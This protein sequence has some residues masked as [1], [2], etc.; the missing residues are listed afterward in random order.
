MKIYTDNIDSLRKNADLLKSGFV[1]TRPQGLIDSFCL[2]MDFYS[3]I[4]DFGQKPDFETEKILEK[5]TKNC[6]IVYQKLRALSK[7]RLQSFID[8]KE[9]HN[10]IAFKMVKIYDRDFIIRSIKPLY[11][12]EN[13]MSEII[14][15]FLNDEFNQAD[16]FKKMA[17]EGR[18]I[19]SGLGKIEEE[20]NTAGFTLYDYLNN[21][22]FI[23]LSNDPS[24]V[25]IQLMS[26]IIHEFGHVNDNFN[27][28]F[29]SKKENFSYKTLSSYSEVY[30]ILYEKLF[31]DHLIKNRI[32]KSNSHT[33]LAF[34][35]AEIYNNFNKLGYLSTLDDNIL[36]NEKYKKRVEDLKAQA[37]VDDEI[38][39]INEAVL[40]DFNDIYTYS[41]SGLIAFYFSYLKQNDPD[42][43][44][45]M[46][47]NFKSRRFRV[48]D[49]GIFDEIGTSKEEIIKIHSEC[50]DRL[51][52]KKLILQ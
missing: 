26:T 16:S 21:N 31:L 19:K 33:Q 6:E 29:F 10:N 43:F 11:L 14:C 5:N 22:S 17:E 1:M 2:L 24:L 37:N 41:Y 38:E 13:Q 46:F 39:L 9:V 45:K 4:K 8:N 12:N 34:L 49:P 40:G 30:S 35:C 36:N 15:D 47:E 28:R 51:T 23:A 50:L 48:F 52:G 42:M 20:R 3:V 44:N 27:R 18:I 7:R 32:F 25:D